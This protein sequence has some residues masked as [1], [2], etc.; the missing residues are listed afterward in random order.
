MNFKFL[1]LTALIITLISIVSCSSDNESSNSKIRTDFDIDIVSGI[2]I[3]NSDLATPTQLGNPNIFTDERFIVYPNP[4]L[5]MLA[6][7][8]NFD[9]SDIYIIS[10]QATKS[11]QQTDF[12]SILTSE[13]YN[14]SVIASNAEI[15]ITDLTAT[16]L[17]INLNELSHGY[18]KVFVKING[19][20]Y[21]DNI[22]FQD[23]N[24]DI[25][26]LINYWN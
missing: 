20:L 23:N 11:Y 2:N 3:R 1:K 16:N 5:G 13:S 12:T 17:N 8:S 6:L 26:T 9:I 22:Y 19:K 7:K 18:Y 10:A 25:D 15:K 4:T 14:E 24:L 21:W